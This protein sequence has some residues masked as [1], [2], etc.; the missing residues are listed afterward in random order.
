MTTEKKK[1][2]KSTGQMLKAQDFEALLADLNETKARDN[3]RDFAKRTTQKPIS[4]FDDLL[5]FFPRYALKTEVNAEKETVMTKE[6]QPLAMEVLNFCLENGAN[7]NAYMKDGENAYLEACK[8]PSTEILD[9]LINNKW[10]PV[11][12]THS[13]GRNGNGLFYAVMA[14]AT[15]VIEYL[16]KNC[17]FN[18]DEKNFLSNNQTVLHFACGHAKEKSFDKLMELGAN[19]TI[20]DFNGYQP[21]EMMLPAYDP[22]TIEEMADEP[23]ELQKWAILY[24]K[25]TAQTEDYR[26]KNKPKLKT[27]F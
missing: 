9:H 20:K 14:E 10:T 15:D 25:V 7:P 11:D 1:T 16:V 26:S 23:E 6:L 21:F 13:D 4:E 8:L 17:N 3:L 27:K 22:D 12:L 19:P 5:F 24:E 18:V 2:Y